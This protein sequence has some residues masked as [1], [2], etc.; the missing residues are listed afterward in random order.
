[1]TKD[2]WRPLFLCEAIRE[3]PDY[4]LGDYE[5]RMIV[6][7]AVVTFLSGCDQPP[8]PKSTGTPVSVG[9]LYDD[10]QPALSNAGGRHIDLD[11]IKDTDTHI[12]EVSRFP[13]GS[14]VLIE[15]SLESRRITNL[16]VCADPNQPTEKLT[17][18]SVK[19][20]YPGQD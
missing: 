4:M 20:F 3:L 9:M 5:M 6:C 17:W 2:A 13:N 1:M 10:A 15:I 19:E 11:G 18:N 12:L 16:K 14:L 7:L 8:P